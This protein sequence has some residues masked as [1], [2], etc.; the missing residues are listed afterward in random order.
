MSG[1]HNCLG[2][3]KCTDSGGLLGD[4]VI[5]FVSNIYI[6]FDKQKFVCLSSNSRADCWR[7]LVKLNIAQMVSIH[8]SAILSDCVITNSG[9]SNPSLSTAKKNMQ[10]DGQW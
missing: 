6:N 9:N 4:E 7:V 1:I 2:C 3:V 5:N 8:I 10:T